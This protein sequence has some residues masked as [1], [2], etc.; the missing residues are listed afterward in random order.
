ME[1]ENQVEEPEPKSAT[2][3]SAI[4]DIDDVSQGGRKKK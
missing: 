3:V 1:D 4:S 2:D